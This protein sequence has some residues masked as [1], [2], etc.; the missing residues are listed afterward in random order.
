MMRYIARNKARLKKYLIE[1]QEIE[2]TKKKEMGE[3]NPEGK[4]LLDELEALSKS[5][6]DKDAEVRKQIQI[7]VDDLRENTVLKDYVKAIDDDVKKQAEEIK[8]DVSLFYLTNDEDL[9]IRYNP[10]Y[11][12][13]MHILLK[14]MGEEIIE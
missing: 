11:Y 10:S 14:H 12:P 3:E 1:L 2:E 8:R 4:D 6:E 5:M 13:N 9:A 7:D